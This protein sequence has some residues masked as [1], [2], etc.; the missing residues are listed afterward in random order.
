[1]KVAI[2][3]GSR[4]DIERMRGAASVLKEFSVEY[5]AFILSA[6]RVPEKLTEVLNDLE[7]DGYECI[8]AAAGL[9]AHLPG[10][11]AS[12]TILPV[13]GVPID[14]GMQGID[15]LLSIVQMPKPIPVATV[16]I[17]NSSNAAMLA[18]QILSV[19]YPELKQ[20]LI[21]YR[22]DMKIKFIEDNTEGVEL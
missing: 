9:A 11:I 15:A 16:G 18:V 7:S 12:K 17:N 3:F 8:I 13:I 6:H 4:S 5:K 19:K 2:I 1:M 21:Q 10:V 20:K 22:E 14:A